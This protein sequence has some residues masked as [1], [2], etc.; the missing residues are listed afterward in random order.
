MPRPS[1]RKTP[2]TAATPILC[3]GDSEDYDDCDDDIYRRGQNTDKGEKS[4]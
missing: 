4:E 3:I 2:A 1:N